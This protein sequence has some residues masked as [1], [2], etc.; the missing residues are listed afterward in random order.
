MKTIQ[1]LLQTEIKQLDETIINHLA[2]DVVLINQ[3][4][5]YIINSGGK[6]LRPLLLILMSKGLNYQG[7]HHIILA[8]VIELIHT[9]TLLHDDVVDESSM[10]RNKETANEVWGNAASVLVGDF[11]YSRSFEMMLEPQ[12][13]EVMNIM[14][15]TTNIIAQ[16]EVLQLLNTQNLELTEKEYFLMI[17]R[18]TACL[19]EAATK[20]AGVLTKTQHKKEIAN[21]GLYLG[22]AFQIVDD[23]LD[24]TADSE[25]IGKNVGDDLREGKMTLPVIYT[26]QK[27]S[28]K[29]KNYLKKILLAKEI[30]SEEV[31]KCVSMIKET[32]AFA[33]SL[34][35]AHSFVN[36]AKKSLSVLEDSIYKDALIKIADLSL[37][38]IK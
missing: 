24:Y 16:G 29:N 12:E 35:Q 17:E 36:K 3:I 11:L 19:F 26:L 22:T 20:I 32:N 10:R 15:K 13:M 21:Y 28:E 4:S 30:T 5:T 38:R 18:K 2:S 34:E 1:K 31:N 14:A 33:Y 8:A 23:I 9:A 7:K 25:T 6:R 27:T 37:N